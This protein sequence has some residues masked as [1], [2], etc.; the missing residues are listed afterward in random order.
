MIERFMKIIFVAFL[1]M[2]LSPVVVKADFILTLDFEFSGA[3]SP[4]GDPPWLT[5]TFEDIYIN[6][7]HTNKVGLTLSAV[8]LVEEECI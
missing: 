3:Q 4:E 2:L 5:A 7:L 6:G 8:G 1:V